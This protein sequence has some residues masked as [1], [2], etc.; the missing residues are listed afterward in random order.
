MLFGV[1]LLFL[2]FVMFV[3]ELFGGGFFEMIFGMGVFVGWVGF[4]F[5]MLV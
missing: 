1:V 4:V 5:V 2:F 3:V